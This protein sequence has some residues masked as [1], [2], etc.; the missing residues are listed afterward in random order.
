MQKLAIIIGSNGALGK[1]LTSR[2]QSSTWKTVLCDVSPLNATNPNFIQLH[3]DMRINV[4]NLDRVLQTAKD[5]SGAEVHSVINVGGGFRMGN[6]RSADL[7]DHL[8][9]MYSSSVESSFL[10][11][12]MAAKHMV[13]GGLLILT[14]ASAALGGTPW[15]LSYGAMK[16][17]VHHMVKSL[18]CTGSGLPNG[19]RTIGIAPVMLDTPANRSSMPDADFTSWT[20]T[21]VVAEKIFRWSDGL[22]DPE[23]G[24]IFKITTESGK[25][26]FTAV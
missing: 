17:G 8:S 7:F 23:N 5:T 12:H 15:A 25:T 26:H 20:E 18:S 19:S 24:A 9:A 22:E 2:F 14:G 1:S 16:A 10:A 21:S 3:H 13:P 6:S 11:A 4:E